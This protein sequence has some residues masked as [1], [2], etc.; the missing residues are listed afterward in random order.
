VGRFRAAHATYSAGNQYPSTP[1]TT[2]WFDPTDGSFRQA[3][4]PFETPG[5]NAAGDHDW[6]LVF[7]APARPSTGGTATSTG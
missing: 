5:K 4:E 3:S 1:S 2:Q 7:D 6:V